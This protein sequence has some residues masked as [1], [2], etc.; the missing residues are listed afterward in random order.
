VGGVFP[1]NGDGTPLAQRYVEGLH[2]ERTSRHRGL[3][4]T[5]GAPLRVRI[6]QPLHTELYPQGSE[7][8]PALERDAGLLGIA[9]W[10]L[11]LRWFAARPTEVRDARRRAYAS[12]FSITTL[13]RSIM[14]GL[15]WSAEGPDR[16]RARVC[17]K[18]PWRAHNI[19]IAHELM[20]TLGASGQVR[21]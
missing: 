10:S 3:L 2:R 4:R 19:V 7:L 20:H 9:W 16:Y 6:E 8:P 13:R 18:P 12:S 21:P 17:A 11:K 14:C 5:R 15:A 1:L